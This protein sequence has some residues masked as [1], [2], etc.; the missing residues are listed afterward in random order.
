M[1]RV[2]QM[3]G[4]GVTLLG[5]AAATVMACG[6]PPTPP[7]PPP[8]P[9]IVCCQVIEWIPAP[10]GTPTECLTVRYFRK[11][12]LPLF[13]SNPMPLGLGQQCLCAVPPLPTFAQAA[14]VVIEGLTFGAGPTCRLL[15]P[16]VPGFG[17]FEPDPDPNLQFQVDQFFDVY[18]QAAADPNVIPPD[19]GFSTPWTFR[20]PG[21]IP[22]NQVFDIYQKIRIPA[23]FDP[24]L[25]CIPGQDWVL[26]L[27][28][29]DNGQVF[30]EPGTAGAAPI[31]LTAFGGNPGNSAIY[32]FRWYPVIVPGPCPCPSGPACA[33]DVDG[34]GDV[35]L[36]DLNLVLFNFGLICP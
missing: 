35:D 26:G 19:S 9:P 5:T 23:G 11:D 34:D 32:K 29:V 20:G 2:C 24:N 28:F 25:L 17:P 4:M 15:P 31:P 13:Q 21:Q 7:P 14:G 1:N 30:V 27:F 12:G 33:G 6:S 10:D 18:V 22:A 8:A 36:Q 16:N 3:L